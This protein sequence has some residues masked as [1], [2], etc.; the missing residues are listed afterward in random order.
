MAK[1]PKTLG[2]CADLLYKLREE[3]SALSK[4][5]KKLE[6]EIN[7]IKEYVIKT[8]PKSKAEGVTGKVANIQ[9]KT[10]DVPHVVDW[11]K[12]RKHITRTKNW[13]LL[14]RSVAAAAVKERWDAGKKVPGIDPYT[15]T[16]VSITKK[17]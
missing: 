6:S 9:V 17:K 7:E 1:I 11:E 13:D 16:K 15:V 5:V 2:A 8:L 4:K 10:K 3:K 12:L 14:T